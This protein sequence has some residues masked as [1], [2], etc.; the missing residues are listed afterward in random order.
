MKL[1]IK[2][3]LI[4]LIFFVAGNNVTY[5]QSYELGSPSK[6]TKLIVKVNSEKELVYSIEQKGSPILAWSDLGLQ[7]KKKVIGQNIRVQKQ[8]KRSVKQQLAWTLGENS[9]ITNHFN[10]LTLFCQSSGIDFQV[11][12]RAFNGSIAF[13][14]IVPKQTQLVSE[15]IQKE[16][17]TFNFTDIYTL[18]QY[19]QES[20]FTPL[21]IDSL[22]KTCDFPATLVSQK[23]YVSIGEAE[24]NSY[25]KAE[26]TK[27]KLANSLA[28]AFLKD[29]VRL[30]TDLATPWRT[31]SIANNAI[32]LHQFSDLPYRLS[33]RFGDTI[34]TWIKPGKVVRLSLNT[35]DG[36]TGIDFA[37][38]HNFQY[39]LF[40]AGWY[41]P[42]FRSASDPTQIIP[43]L[44]LHRVI[45]YGKEKGIGVI[46]YV[47]KVGLRAHLDEILPLYKKWG[48]AGFKFGFVDGLS[49]EGI[50]WLNN[51]IK[52]TLDYGF[53]LNIHD[54]YKPTGLSHTYPNLLTQE[55]IRGNENAPDAYHNMVLPFTRFL[56]G[57]A[58]YTYCYPNSVKSFANKLLVSK[59]QQLA[60][61]VVYFSPLQAI[62]WYGNPA[63]YTNETEIE[64]FK[65]V[66]TVWDESHYLQGEI[67][68]YISVARRKGTT[69]YLGNAT[70]F[71]D[72][73]GNLSLDFLT[74]NKT[75]KMTIFEDDETK[76]IRKRVLEVKKGY[77]LAINLKAKG[78][79]AI[80]LE[81]VNR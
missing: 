44:D 64:F 62:F 73:E 65:Y 60:L 72:W 70:G 19:N 22:I 77:Q 9:T 20:V 80:T 25:T 37:A 51:A 29:S 21:A 47:N 11:V 2:K 79:Q 5:G 1:S 30:T 54:N 46:L 15:E 67:G 12:F 28:V 59:G 75:Y 42:E 4:V 10:E 43:E 81:E 7:L 55:G 61:S 40:D 27:G 74:S 32:G 57:A 52:K 31:V 6:D 24:N 56:A 49:Q 68:K 66:P 41:G 69:W 50:V 17:S 58:D 39:I 8:K 18:Y 35:Q 71:S 34:P 76:G 36:I 45:Q 33:K 16:L 53:I 3:I 23:Y 63:D 26:L 14:Y 78:G 13:R 48:V 38:A